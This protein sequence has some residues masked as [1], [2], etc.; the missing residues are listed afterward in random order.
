M[1]MVKKALHGGVGDY[2]FELNSCKVRRQYRIFH[3]QLVDLRWSAVSL[4]H[5]ASSMTAREGR[6]SSCSIFLLG[7]LLHLVSR[8]FIVPE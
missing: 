7:S 3:M 1:I 4:L 8:V 6:C 5:V 2:K